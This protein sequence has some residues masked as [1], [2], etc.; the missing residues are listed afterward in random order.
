MRSRGP[1][2]RPCVKAWC[3]HAQRQWEVKGGGDRQTR[4]SLA[5]QPSRNL[6]S[7][8]LIQGDKEDTAW[9]TK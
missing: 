1:E 4:G 6:N 2:F 9:K 7:E 3:S 5:C 8:L